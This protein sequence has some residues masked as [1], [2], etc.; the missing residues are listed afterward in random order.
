M[1]LLDFGFVSAKQGAHALKR[2]I[3]VSVGPNELR[4]HELFQ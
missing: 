3:Y 4:K 2:S 1:V